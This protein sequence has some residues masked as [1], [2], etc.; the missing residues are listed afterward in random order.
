MTLAALALPMS[1]LLGSSLQVS[2]DSFSDATLFS[3]TSGSKLDLRVAELTSAA[4]ANSATHM[5]IEQLSPVDTSNPAVLGSAY[6]AIDIATGE[7]QDTGVLYL[8]LPGGISVPEGSVSSPIVGIVERAGAWSAYGLQDPGSQLGGTDGNGSYDGATISMTLTISG[9]DYTGT[10]SYSVVDESTLQLEPFTVSRQGGASY[11]FSGGPLLRN[12]SDFSGSLA[13]QNAGAEYNSFFYQMSLTGIPDL[14]G[15]GIPD[16]ADLDISPSGDLEPGTLNNTVFGM[17]YGISNRWG[18]SDQLGFVYMPGGYFTW[19]ASL[20]WLALAGA[21]YSPDTV[22]WLYSETHGWI[23]SN[24]SLGSSYARLASSN[25]IDW[26][27]GDFM[28]ASSASM[29]Q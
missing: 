21:S 18:Y 27:W 8:N 20:G 2:I 16:I 13:N 29:F 1:S 25:P 10:A 12:G 17:V 11:A 15:D 3:I 14:D 28:E 22:L 6:S 26:Q 24:S 23:Y 9:Q 7:V 5:L 19:H 4:G